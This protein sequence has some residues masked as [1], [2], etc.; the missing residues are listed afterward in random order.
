M[1]R[2]LNGSRAQVIP[3][4]A[5]AGSLPLMGLMLV[6]PMISS[7]LASALFGLYGLAIACF[8]LGS[9]WG[10]A[11]VSAPRALL[12]VAELAA[13]NALLLVVVLCHAVFDGAIVLLLQAGLFIVILLLEQ[14]MPRLRAAP[15]YYRS[16]R[17]Q[18]TALVSLV[19]VGFAV[20][21]LLS[22]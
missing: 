1:A 3:L 14:A 7:G 16:M 12:P 13:S 2:A 9:W 20:W 22:A 8:L 18:V 5:F 4:L 21:L 15:Q 19:H 17:R 6:S 10:I 11:L